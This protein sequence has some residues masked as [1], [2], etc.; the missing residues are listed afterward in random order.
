MSIA[1][2]W[3]ISKGGMPEATLQA[4]LIF[5]AFFVFGMAWASYWDIRESFRKNDDSKN[6]TEL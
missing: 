2:L 6:E 3:V 1:G 4:K 5:V